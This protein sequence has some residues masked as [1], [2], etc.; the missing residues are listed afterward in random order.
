MLSQ[1]VTIPKGCFFTVLGPSGCG[2]STL[3]RMIAGPET[4]DHGKIA[5]ERR[6]I[7]GPGL[8]LPPEARGVGVVF[9]SYAL[10]PHMDVLGSI[11]FPIEAAG[12][13]QRTARTA[14]QQHLDAVDLSRFAE[15][16]DG[17]R[18]DRISRTR[19]GHNIVHFP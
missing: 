16:R 12:T 10:W 15:R 9:Q 7:S 5:L 19:R 14:A 3:L 18:N 13:N 6:A 4:L 11:A 17:R 1:N 8:H 2:K